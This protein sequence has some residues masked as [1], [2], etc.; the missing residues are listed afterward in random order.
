M[1]QPIAVTRKPSPRP[2]VVRLEIN[3]SLTGMGHEHYE[4]AAEAASGERPPDVLARRLF[5]HSGVTK[6]YVYGNIIQVE[7]ASGTNAAEIEEVV[8]E[9]YRHYTP[10]VTP[11]VAP[12]P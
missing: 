4:S 12:A 1:G 5:E 9:L 2:D 6:V 8:R 3:R 7:I 11:S 10:G